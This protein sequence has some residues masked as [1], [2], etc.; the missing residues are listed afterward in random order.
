M[1]GAGPALSAA[2]A[3]GRQRVELIDADHAGSKMTGSSKDACKGT[4]TGMLINTDR[5]E[6][7][8]WG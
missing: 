6:G 7:Q 5:A 4:Q 3:G 8:G 1:V 2:A